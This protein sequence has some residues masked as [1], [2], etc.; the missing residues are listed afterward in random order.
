MFAKLPEPDRHRLVVYIEDHKV[1]AFA[2]ETVACVLLRSAQPVART[3]PVSG[4]PR[5]PY[6][7]MGVCF[8]CLAI[9]DG[10][11]FVQTCLTTVRDGMRIARQLGAP[12]V[13]NVAAL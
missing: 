10:K 8:D 1:E 5:L 11:P 9:V 12:E 7:M 2:G 4:S 13:G 6:C 3:T